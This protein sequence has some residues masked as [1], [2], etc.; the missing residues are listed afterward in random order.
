MSVTSTLRTM[1]LAA[2]AAAIGATAQAQTAHIHFFGHGVVTYA[3]DGYLNSSF[4]PAP[5]T[6]GDLV[7]VDGDI[8]VPGSLT[9]Q[10]GTFVMQ[11]LHHGQHETPADAFRFNVSG[12]ADST[13]TRDFCIN[14]YGDFTLDHGQ[15][16]ALNLSNDTDPDTYNLS[17]QFFGVYFD[18]GA[19]DDPPNWGGTWVLDKGSV[20]PEPAVWI[21]MV[22]GFGALGAALRNKRRTE[23]ET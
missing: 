22:L 6:V 13:D 12:G 19:G 1:L 21:T 7:H 18:Q 23:S 4:F 17:T 11:D 3:N 10:S 5:V 16:V 2:A 14:A 15:L 8:W 9:G 20:T